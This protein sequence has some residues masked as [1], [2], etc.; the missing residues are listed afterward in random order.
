MYMDELLKLLYEKTNLSKKMEENKEKMCLENEKLEKMT[1]FIQKCNNQ[2]KISL[3]FSVL[4]GTASITVFFQLFGGVL[5]IISTFFEMIAYERWKKY[6]SNAEKIKV[7][8]VESIKKL[9]ADNIDLS[10]EYLL[11]EKK[12]AFLDQRKKSSM[13]DLQV[14]VEIISEELIDE[15]IASAKTPIQEQIETLKKEKEDLLNQSE[16]IDSCQNRKM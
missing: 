9:E 12:I 15:E 1:K 13:D 6:K 5:F 14:E 2:K 4:F 16:T 3:F 11:T 10:N 7:G 8:L